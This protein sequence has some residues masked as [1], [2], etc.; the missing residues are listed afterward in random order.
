MIKATIFKRN[1][2]SCGFHIKGHSGYA[3]SGSDIICSAVSA[4]AQ[5]TLLGLLE[6]VSPTLDYS[7]SDHG[8]II[9]NIPKDLNETALKH[10]ALLIDVLRLGLESIQDNYG[11]Y[12]RVSEREVT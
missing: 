10:A 1:G 3:E 4:V 8:E 6:Y 2:S 5:T 7:I 12:L 9:C 11:E